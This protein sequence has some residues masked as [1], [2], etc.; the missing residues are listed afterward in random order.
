VL[1]HFLSYYFLRLH[2]ENVLIKKNKAHKTPSIL[3][4]NYYMF[5]HQGAGLKEFTNNKGSY[6]QHV[7][8]VL[9]VSIFIIIF[10]LKAW[11]RNMQELIPNMKCILLYVLLYLTP[12]VG[13]HMEQH[14]LFQFSASSR[15]PKVIQQLLTF[16]F[17]FSSHSCPSFYLS[18][19][20][21]S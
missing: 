11:C 12:F 7:L 8:Q 15:F 17:S 16:S 6:F 4:T 3:G 20:N 21:V 19:N 1:P 14:F 5:R 18:F 13:S 2:R 10:I 9:V